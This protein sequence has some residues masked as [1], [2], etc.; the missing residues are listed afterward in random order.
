M[1]DKRTPK[2]D[3]GEANILSEKSPY[4]G[5][6]LFAKQE[7]IT[8]ARLFGQD[9]ATG[10]NFCFNQCHTKSFAFFLGKLLYRSNRELFSGVCIA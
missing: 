4:F 5:K 10:K 3:C 2:D 9:F 1:R 7:L 6:H 8:R